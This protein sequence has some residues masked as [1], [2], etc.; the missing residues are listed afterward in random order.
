MNIGMV[1]WKQV[2][3]STKFCKTDDPHKF[4][5]PEPG[6]IEQLFSAHPNVC[7]RIDLSSAEAIHSIP[8]TPPIRISLPNIPLDT[9]TI[10][11]VPGA[12]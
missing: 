6:P 10:L 7:P 12:L 9:D 8:K 11:K 3:E 5:I 4:H 2:R 1:D